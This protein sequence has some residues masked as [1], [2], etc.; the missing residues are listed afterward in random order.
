MS[1]VYHVLCSGCPQAYIGQTSRTLAWRLK[2][3]HR[4]VRIGDS[5]TS[6]LAEHAHS[7]G[8]PIDWTAVHAITHAPIPPGDACSSPG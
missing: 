1:Y 6:V 7:T 8:L 4:A 2:E 3:H 5:A